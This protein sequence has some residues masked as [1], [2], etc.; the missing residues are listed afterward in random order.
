MSV[1][2]AAAVILLILITGAGIGFASYT[3]RVC[4]ELLEMNAA[5]AVSFD[6]VKLSEAAEAWRSRA[7]ILSCLIPHD[8]IDRITE[9][10]MKASVYIELGC[11]EE[12]SAELQSIKAGLTVL[13]NY[14]KPTLR[15]VF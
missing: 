15:S 1:R 7:D 4:G 10:Y 13:Q 5:A 6:K 9:S 12:Y 8:H 14:D 2:V 11:L 3:A